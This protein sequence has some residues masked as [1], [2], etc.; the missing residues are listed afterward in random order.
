MSATT[1]SLLVLACLTPSAAGTAQTPSCPGGRASTAVEEH[2]WVE[3]HARDVVVKHVF[4][5][6]TG[7]GY[8]FADTAGPFVTAPKFSWPTSVIFKLWR[9]LVYPGAALVIRLEP[10]G[11]W[12]R[13][14]LETR[15]QCE[16]GQRPPPGHPQDVD[17]QTFVLSQTHAEASWAIMSRLGHETVRSFAESCAPLDDGDPKIEVC[18]RMAEAQPRNPEA[19]RQYVL[20]L[21]RFYRA[22]DAWKPLSELF[23]LEGE[24]PST[25]GEVGAAMLGARQFDDARKLFERATALWPA[26]PTMPYHLG[27]AHLGLHAFGP[28]ADAFAVA[29]RLDSTLADA[30][31]YSAV[32]LAQLGRLDDSRRHCAIATRYLEAALVDRVADVDAWLGLAYCAGIVARDR[33]AVSYFERALAIDASGARATPELVDVIK[34]SYGAVGPQPP[35]PLPQRP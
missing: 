24:R 29:V 34:T 23:A 9:G 2:T 22:R 18:R 15:L 5:A 7:L 3:P 13:I 35:A 1:H 21:A 28:A 25:Y 10:T 4:K 19:L 17:F 11:P 20:A 6:I 32:A 33:E 31:A 30:H 14:R 16:T 27:R 26:D 12:T 8:S